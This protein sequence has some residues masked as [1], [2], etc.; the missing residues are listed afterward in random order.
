MNIDDSLCLPN[1]ALYNIGR[2]C[3]LVLA[4]ELRIVL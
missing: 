1:P 3:P 2:L 4:Q